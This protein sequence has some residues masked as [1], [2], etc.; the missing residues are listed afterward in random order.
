MPD[1]MGSTKKHTLGEAVELDDLCLLVTIHEEASSSGVS[2]PSANEPK[3][4]VD[5]NGGVAG[6]GIGVA[7]VSG[8][9]RWRW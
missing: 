3:E 6:D 1:R 7:G 9:I 5:G 8:S 2:I 4:G